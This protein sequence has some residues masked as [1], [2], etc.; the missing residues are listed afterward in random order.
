MCVF[1]A[2]LQPGVVQGLVDCDSLCR[3]QHQHAPH[4][5]LGAL[6]DVSPLARVHLH[7]HVQNHLKLVAETRKK[8]VDFEN[9]C[10]SEE[11]NKKKS[12]SPQGTYKKTTKMRKKVAC[13]NDH[14][15]GLI[16]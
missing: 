9:V 2:H 5:V 1:V 13:S 16:W 4:Q 14:D 15:F 8:K 11:S 6:R 12:C 7:K 10:D 3:V